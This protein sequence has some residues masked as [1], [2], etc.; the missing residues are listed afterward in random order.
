MFLAPSADDGQSQAGKSAYRLGKGADG[1]FTA[2][3]LVQAA[4]P[5]ETNAGPVPLGFG[6]HHLLFRHGGF[7]HALD[8]PPK[9]PGHA[10]PRV[11]V[12]DQDSVGEVKAEVNVRKNIAVQHAEGTQEFG[13]D[14]RARPRQ[15]FPRANLSAAQ[16]AEHHRFGTKPPETRLA[17]RIKGRV[18]NQI[19]RSDLPAQV[20]AN[21]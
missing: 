17:K 20:E 1:Q 2:L 21:P 8:F 15:E 10:L 19:K 18:M 11:F 5:E 14:L 7:E 9:K 13:H 3:Q 4:D 6:F 12:G 16:R